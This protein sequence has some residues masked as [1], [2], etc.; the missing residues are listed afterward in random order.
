M[1]GTPRLALPFLSP[2]QAQKEFTHNE[3][4]QT[5]DIVISL[6]V[7]EGPRAD[8]PV[9]PQIGACYIVDASAT[10]A[11]AG[12]SQSVAGFTTGGWRFVAPLEGMAAYVKATS[13]WAVYRSG[14][15]ELGVVRGSTVQVGDQQ[16]IASR[17]AAIA[18]ATGGATIDI[19]VRAVVDQ[20]LGAL[21]HHGLIET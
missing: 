3:A 15:W 7:E 4:L 17:A 12:Q 11:W 13:I 20:I 2:G 10:G 14:G 8:P 9:A 18:S 21:R 1:T 6:A 5:V 19:E 16:V